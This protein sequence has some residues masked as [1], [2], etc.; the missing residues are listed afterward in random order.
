MIT[1]FL[2]KSKSQTKI[3]MIHAI[4]MELYLH[5]CNLFCDK[6]LK[7]NLNRSSVIVQSEYVCLGF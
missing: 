5:D 7:N 2:E 4:D 3:A 1:F 6:G